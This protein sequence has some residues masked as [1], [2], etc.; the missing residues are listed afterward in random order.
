[1]EEH[2]I[3][4]KN[5]QP[6]MRHNEQNH[7]PHTVNSRLRGWISS[8]ISL[9]FPKLFIIQICNAMLSSLFLSIYN[10]HGKPYYQS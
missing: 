4:E 10:I 6:K 2:I 7:I 8:C 3:R 5:G 1:M 9:V